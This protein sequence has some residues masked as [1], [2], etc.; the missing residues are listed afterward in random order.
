M[1]K[2]SEIGQVSFHFI[3]FLDKIFDMEA[4]ALA[5]IYHLKFYLLM[6]GMNSNFINFTKMVQEGCIGTSLLQIQIILSPDWCNVK[7]AETV[8]PAKKIDFTKCS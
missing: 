4:Y 5:K 3:Q 7:I 1:V 2:S 6:L 8:D